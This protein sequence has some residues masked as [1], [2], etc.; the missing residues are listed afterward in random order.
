M[1]AFIQLFFYIAI[2]QQNYKFDVIPT[3]NW[4]SVAQL[5]A[6]TVRE[7]SGPGLNNTPHTLMGLELRSLLLQG[8]L[9]GLVLHSLS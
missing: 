3:H 7:R 9:R 2:L 1:R 6:A 8:S 5:S 4:A